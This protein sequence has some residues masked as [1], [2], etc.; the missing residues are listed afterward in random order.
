LLLPLA[1]AP[2]IAVMS[3]SGMETML[4]V[5]LQAAAFVAYVERRPRLLG[6]LAALLILTR[7]DG[8]LVIAAIL[9]TDGL[10]R[11]R[12]WQGRM[13]EDEMAR[14]W[15]I[16]DTLRGAVI[17]IALLLPWV[18]FTTWY[19]GNFIPNSVLAKR[20]LYSE[21]GLVGTEPLEVLQYVFGLG[22]MLPWQLGATF[23]IA[24]LVYLA[25]R[26]DRLSSIVVWF[27]AYLVF[28]TFAHTH[29][30]PWYLPPFYAFALLSVCALSKVA[31]ATLPRLATD[32]RAR[33]VF[34]AACWVFV[35]LAG[36]GS[37]FAAR[38]FASFL[39]GNYERAHIDVA[40]FLDANADATDVIYAPDIGYVGAI[41]GRRI[42]DAVGI[43]SPE[44]IPFNKRGDYAGVLRAMQPPWAIIGLYE[45]WQAALLG[46]PWVRKNYKPVYRNKPDRPVD[47]PP[48]K[49]LAEIEYDWDYLVLKRVRE[50]GAQH[51]RGP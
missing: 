2:Y 48:T 27:A 10:L 7:I 25:V 41:T 22:Y 36:A 46:D 31:S 44:V 15:P 1:I 49:E 43:V 40:R 16:A 45:H 3:V 8:S 17:A 9:V 13:T 39:Q 33:L 38:T 23:T 35:I 50:K 37:I 18:A 29:V 51:G 32:G 30:H 24:G 6:V 5:F 20:V 11:L 12:R 4:F 47:W 14:P 19:Y 21:G 42:L 26:R 34:F 28:L